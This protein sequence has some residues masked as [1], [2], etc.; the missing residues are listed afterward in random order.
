MNHCRFC[1]IAKGE[2]DAFTV[3]KSDHVLAFLDVNPIIEGHTLVIPVEHHTG[4]DTLPEETVRELFATASKLTHALEEVLQPDG[5]SLFHTTGPIIGNIDHAHIHLVPRYSEDDIK[6]SLP[7]DELDYETGE[8]LQAD[9]T[10]ELA[11]IE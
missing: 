3:A 4:I 8:H 7:R 5:F 6:I 10:D 1:Q 9:I 2:R 11:S